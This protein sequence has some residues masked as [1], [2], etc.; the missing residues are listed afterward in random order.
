MFSKP[1]SLQ[2]YLEDFYDFCAEI[3]GVTAEVMCPILAF[4]ADRRAITITI[5]SFRTDLLKDDMESLYPKCG[6]LKFETMPDKY[7]ERSA[8]KVAFY[9]CQ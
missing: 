8:S 6:K 4:E 5:N 1:F 2:A 7:F 9:F 3:G